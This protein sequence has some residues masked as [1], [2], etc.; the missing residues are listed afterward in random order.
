MSH[1]FERIEIGER[2]VVFS[3]FF[4]GEPEIEIAD[5]I[6]DVTCIC[7]RKNLEAVAALIDGLL[8]SKPPHQ[9]PSLGNTPP[10]ADSDPGD[11]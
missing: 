5:D 9:P 1:I 2:K 7:G 3:G 10:A 11:R 6:Y 4:E 8:K